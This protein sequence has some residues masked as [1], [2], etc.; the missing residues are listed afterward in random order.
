MMVKGPTQFKDIR[1][2]RWDT[3]TCTLNPYDLLYRRR[4]RNKINGHYKFCD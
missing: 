3:N 4:K 2:K 1:A